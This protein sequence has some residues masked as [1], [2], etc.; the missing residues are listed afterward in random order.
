MPLRYVFVAAVMA[1]A[2]TAASAQ[3]AS[4]QPQPAPAAKEAPTDRVCRKEAETG[5]LVRKRKTCRSRAEWDAMAQ[6]ARNQMTE[7][8]MSGSSSGN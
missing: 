5:S 6:A 4:P 1:M 2:A 3:N 8:Q 7:G